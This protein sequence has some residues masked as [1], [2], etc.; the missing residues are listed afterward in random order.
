[1]GSQRITAWAMTRLRQRRYGWNWR[2][3]ELVLKLRVYGD[4]TEI[5]KMLTL[6][7]EMNIY[8]TN[9]WISSYKTCL[10]LLMCVVAIRIVWSASL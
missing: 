7:N 9:N 6:L 10:H 8:S 1:V 5:E 3:R 4:S 2:A